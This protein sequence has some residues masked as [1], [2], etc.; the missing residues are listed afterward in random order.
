MPCDLTPPAV[1]S[2]FI[3]RL[4]F[5]AVWELGTVSCLARSSWSS[6]CIQ[7]PT[8]AYRI[9]PGVG[10]RVGNGFGQLSPCWIEYSF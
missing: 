9:I 2:P 4:V 5:K 6:A 8:A 7:L 1:R 10:G 3:G